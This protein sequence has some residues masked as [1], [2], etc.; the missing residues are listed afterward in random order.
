MKR[1]LSKILG[2]GLSIALMTSLLVTAVPASALST[3]MVTFGT[4]FV[5]DVISKVDAVHVVTFTVNKQLSGNA[6]KRDS[7]VITFPTGYAIGGAV[8]GII[9]AGPGWVT[10]GVGVD[11]EWDPNPPVLGTNFTS[12]PTFRTITYKLDDTNDYIGEGAQ[13]RVQINTGIT[14]PG[15]PGD[16]T[17]T[18]ATKKTGQLRS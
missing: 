7:I 4:A 15:P 13:V 3:P 11:P 5:D 9:S 2:I 18:V 6:T 14:N 12:N 10:D 17:V 16:Y 1:K 8:T